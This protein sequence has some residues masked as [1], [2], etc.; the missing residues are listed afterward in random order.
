M[1][2][3][4]PARLP[5]LLPTA[6]AAVP[7]KRLNDQVRHGLD[8]DYQLA[9][10]MELLAETFYIYFV[11]KRHNTNGNPATEEER[12]ANHSNYQPIPD[13]KMMR[14]RQ[15]TVLAA[16]IM[17]LNLGVDP[18]DVIKTNP[19]AKME[20]WVD[21]GDH[22]D[23][24][25]AIEQIGKMLQTQYE[26]LS[27]RIRYKQLLDPCVEDMNRFCNTLRKNAKEE[28]ILVHYNGHGVPQP[29][30]SGE[31][32]VFNR[33]YTQYI[34]ILLYDLQTWLGA[35]C[36][37][38][39]DCSSA[40]NIVLNFNKFVQKRVDDEAQGRHE[41]L[42]PSSTQAYTDCIQLA[43]CRANEI[44]P[45][46]PD[47]PADLFTC[48]LTS[49]IDISIRWF[50]S[51][52]PLR[53]SY[54]APLLEN[55][56]PNG[57]IAVPGKLAER[58]TPLGELNWI[59][60]AI[61]DT[62][63]WTL[64][65]RPLFKKL[66]RQDLMVAALFR[67]FLLAKRIMPVH[68]CNP[69][70]D[71]PLPDSIR[72]HHMWELW[73]LA[74]DQVLSQLMR[75]QS[76][77]KGK[78]GVVLGPHANGV[79]KANGHGPVL[80]SI[81]PTVPN[82][83]VPTDLSVY[84]HST[85]FEQHLTAFDNWLKYGLALREPPE[86]L[87]IVLQVL[88]SQVHRIRALG[89]LLRFLDL[90]PWAVYLL[91]L[92]GIFPYVL[93]LLLLPAPELKPVL[94]FIW[95]R[96]MLVDYVNTQQD[97]IKDKGY[98]Y[99]YLY[100]TMPLPPQCDNHKAMCAF[101]L[102]SFIR[103]F[104]SGQRTVFSVELL[105]HLM[106][107]IETNQNPL[108]RQWC[109]LLMLQLWVEHPDGKWIAIR[110]GIAT[111][112]AKAVSDPIPEVRTSILIAFTLFI[113]LEEDRAEVQ[114]QY[115]KFSIAV[116]GLIGDGLSVTRR[117]V[118]VFFAKFMAA[119]KDIFVIAAFSQLEEEI[120]LVDAPQLLQE[121]RKRSPTYGT[122]FS[123][124]WK[125]LLI[126]AED[127]HNE[128]RARAEEMVDWMLLQL[129]TDRELGQY[130]E[131]MEAYLKEHSTGAALL[132]DGPTVFSDQRGSLPASR[133]PSTRGNSSGPASL[134]SLSFLA[135][136]PNQIIVHRINDTRAVLHDTGA[137]ISQLRVQDL[138][139]AATSTDTLKSL[140]LNLLPKVLKA[141]NISSEDSDQFHLTRILNPVARAVYGSE[142]HPTTPRMPRRTA[143]GDMPLMESGFFAYACEYFQEPQMQKP[144]LEVPGSA[145]FTQR[146]WRR[147]RNVA[148]IEE[149]QLLK[150]TAVRGEW[151]HASI[152]LDN[153]TQPEL[154]R[155]TQF[156]NVLVTTNVKDTV[157]VWDWETQ[158]CVSRFLNGNPP[159]TKITE[160]K[161]INEDDTLLL[162][163]GLLD[164][165]VKI[166]RNFQEQ[167]QTEMVAAWRALTDLLPTPKLHGLVC[168]W[169]QLRGLLLVLGDV[170]TI[171]IWDAPRELCVVDVP[172]RLPLLI[173]SLTSDQVA[174]NIFIAGF[175]DGSMRV[176]D[177]RLD[178]R[179][180]LV[181]AWRPKQRSGYV[182]S[183]HMQRG[184]FRELVSG[185]SDG[186]VR[187]WDIRNDDALVTIDA[188]PSRTMRCVRVHEHAPVIAAGLKLV[189][190]WTTA[191]DPMEVVRLPSSLLPRG[192]SSSYVADVAFHPH[193]L[194]MATSYQQS[195]QVHLYKCV[196]T[197]E[198]L[199]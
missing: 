49:P 163:T 159:G 25:R 193:R 138:A 55:A 179:G 170:K 36:I 54:Y 145:E 156:E 160:A 116:L 22:P 113:L 162:L 62:I 127:P 144:D 100:L 166:Y 44:L 58:R 7:R 73:D 32:W 24:R 152:T 8:R 52:S 16:L 88:L 130:A 114:L 188:F 41:D 98:D 74:I 33:G 3:E 38:V 118:L 132:F 173:T 86:Q 164:G 112:L 97:L 79:P 117:E 108:L 151:R 104:R 1:S 26:T 89:L 186:T 18:P 83:P 4:D 181:R 61:T 122:V 106:L 29:T 161:F 103:D 195:S 35:P 137:A 99:F 185:T 11:D 141:L 17:C 140:Y 167:G 157:S 53:K 57:N 21:P 56:L 46:N 147:N 125:S 51:Q 175:A 84:Q 155:F 39:Y 148:I 30:T 42:A 191:G 64:L 69:V 48:C 198:E 34:P 105:H 187:L 14:D 143:V 199:Y 60:T 43:A 77:G 23:L 109:A 189:L 154:L 47:L 168:E 128:V 182:C 119:Y 120:A 72:N 190:M 197:A 2:N 178:L 31:I 136:G 139:G 78:D 196:D 129:R 82:A 6:V 71:P 59:F 40:G 121:V 194:M 85:F 135:P 165:V 171:R 192:G 158:E 66:F 146:L 142:Y 131:E 75:M 126:M 65:L 153:G 63:A 177:R 37:Y 150:L 172:A 176:Y 101:I 169:Q 92:I 91:L 90:G 45:M 87:P 20:A 134:R 76:E 50:I 174:G 67:N 111:R 80:N 94:I 13:W 81:P 95:A 183:V 110:E 102:T 12:A 93:K 5:T 70:S 133:R 184:G 123:S 9:T 107:L 19:C 15:K 96:I 27:P 149:N 115:V 10:F 68:N 28:R 124:I 180:L